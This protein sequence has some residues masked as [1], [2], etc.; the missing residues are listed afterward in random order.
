MQAEMNTMANKSSM[1]KTCKV[2]W[3]YIKE[4]EKDERKYHTL[5]VEDT[6]IGGRDYDRIVRIHL[7]EGKHKK[8]LQDIYRR[9]C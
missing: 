1:K 4:E 6:N 5:A 3:E 9:K 7:D 8:I 2:L